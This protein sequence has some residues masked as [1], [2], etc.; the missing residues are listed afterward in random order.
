MS[1]YLQQSARLSAMAESR[2]AIPSDLERALLIEAGYRCAIPTCRAV[3]P[4]EIDH[5]ED[6]AKVR[7]HEFANMIVLCRN[8]HGLKGEGPRRLDRKALRQIKANLAIVN[9]R[10]G[11]MERRVLMFLAE[12][13]RSANGDTFQIRLPGGLD[14][15]VMYLVNDGLL[16]PL[17]DMTTALLDGKP[18]MQDYRV[19]EAAWDLVTQLRDAQPLPL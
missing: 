7:K 14:L 12:Q 9:G 6:W 11:D 18:V 3:G 8:C 13:P 2:P 10:Y 19:T 4:L 1:G 17:H 15:L 16:V 5:I